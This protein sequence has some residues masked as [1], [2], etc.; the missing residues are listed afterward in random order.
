MPLGTAPFV[1]HES[2][3]HDVCACGL[4]PPE[5]SLYGLGADGVVGIEKENE[6]P[7][8]LA[9]AS[10]TRLHRSHVP[11]VFQHTDARVG[12]GILAHNPHGGI[13]RTVIHGYYFEFAVGLVQHRLQ[14]SGHVRLG[15]INGDDN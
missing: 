4:L 11:L 9:I 2:A 13:G 1:I 15:L 3:G 6:S 12:G 7:A 14:A 5:Q 8:C 10:L